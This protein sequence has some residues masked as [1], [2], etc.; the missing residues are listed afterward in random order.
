MLLTHDNSLLS[1]DGAPKLPALQVLLTRYN[2]PIPGFQAKVGVANR[3]ERQRWLDA[4]LPLF[5]SFCLPS[6]LAQTKRPDLWLL[7]FDGASRDAVAPVIDSIKVHSWIVPVWQDESGDPISSWFS[8]IKREVSLLLQS[9]HS[10]II[11]TRLDNDDAL[12]LTFSK[13]V[14]EHACVVSHSR[15]EL[16][17]YWITFPFGV[18][19]FNKRCFLHFYPENAFQSIVM[20]RARF[21]ERPRIMGTHSSVLRKG[22]TVFQSVTRCP[23]WLRNIHGGNVTSAR[24]GRAKLA[25]VPT[26]RVLR[27]FGLDRNTLENVHAWS[28][29]A[30]RFLVRL[31]KGSWPRPRI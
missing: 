17:E 19:Y 1:P 3:A 23:M 13:H 18:D 22:F 26:H 30:Q 15:P 21:V 9:D 16:Q 14:Y 2:L 6:V 28:A 29:P 4:R 20:T 27:Q 8:A 7:G 11:F 12:E 10:H 24:S 31:L 5:R 25:L